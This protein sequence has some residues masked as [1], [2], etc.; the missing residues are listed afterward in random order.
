MA[1]TFFQ[2]TEQFENLKRLSEL[3]KKFGALSLEE[4]NVVIGIFR[5]FVGFDN[6]YEEVNALVL[7]KQQ[8]KE[9]DQ[10]I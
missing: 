7:Q 10:M 9:K 6:H 5:F 1:M 8:I 2:T 4:A 3:Y